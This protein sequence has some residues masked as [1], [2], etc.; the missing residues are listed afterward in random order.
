MSTY[1]VEKS[2][3]YLVSTLA[4]RGRQRKIPRGQVRVEKGDAAKLAA[5]IVR[6][7]DAARAL[8]LADTQPGR[9]VE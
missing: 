1:L 5:E 6:Q 9:P 4:K 2:D 3:H 8:L 7:A